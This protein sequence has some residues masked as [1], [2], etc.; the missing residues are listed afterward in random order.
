MLQQLVRLI[1]MSRR[2]TRVPAQVAP[3]PAKQTQLVAM[4]RLAGL[5]L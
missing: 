4:A 1:S 3:V 5:L 2:R